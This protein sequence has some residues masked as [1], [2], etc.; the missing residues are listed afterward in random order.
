MKTGFF[1]IVPQCCFLFSER[2]SR[3]EAS[4]HNKISSAPLSTVTSHGMREPTG[5]KVH[6][7]CVMIFLRVFFY[8]SEQSENFFLHELQQIC[9][10]RTCK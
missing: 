3:N 5:D 1:S 10:N 4:L 6:I 7:V 2:Q 8:Y 9:I